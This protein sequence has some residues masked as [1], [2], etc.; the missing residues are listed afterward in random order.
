MVNGLAKSCLLLQQVAQRLN[1][2]VR[3]VDTVARLGGDEFVV[4]LEA[5]SPD[6]DMLA[7]EARDKL[8]PATLPVFVFLSFHC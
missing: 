4:M 2:C 5:L 1:G 8:K 7:I 3:T 6:P